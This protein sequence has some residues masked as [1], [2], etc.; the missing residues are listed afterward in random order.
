M[1]KQL[2]LFAALFIGIPVIL[3][4]V[5]SLFAI[6]AFKTKFATDSYTIATKI[7]TIAKFSNGERMYSPIFHYTIQDKNYIHTTNSSTSNKSFSNKI[8]YN[9]KNPNIC[10]SEFELITFYTSVIILAIISIPMMWIGFKVLNVALFKIKKFKKL[11]QRGKLIKNLP[12]KIIPANITFNDQKGYY[13]EIEYEIQGG[14]ILNL[15]SEV[16]FNKYPD[17]QTTAELLIDPLD[18]KNYFIDFNINLQH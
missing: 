10:I 5:F 14:N 12:C 3:W 2:K 8:Y 7:E 4:L 15:K 9:S 11:T 17:N 6:P 13:I 16:K 18:A 1:D